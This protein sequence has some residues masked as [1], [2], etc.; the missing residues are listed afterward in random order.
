MRPFGKLIGDQKLLDGAPT[1]VEFAGNR[2]HT[3]ALRVEVADFFKTGNPPGPALVLV[4]FSARTAPRIRCHFTG[5]AGCC[6]D[7]RHR[8]RRWLHWRR[9][10]W[11]CRHR[12][13][14]GRPQTGLV[15]IKQALQG[16]PEI[17]EQMKPIRHLDRLG[18]TTRGSVRKRFGA[19]PTNHFHAGV[20]LQPLNQR[21]RQTIR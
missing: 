7:Y 14:G 9:I 10:A 8:R 5:G 2:P 20:I 1:D 6:R 18:R 13:G 4:L 16:F 12:I 21:V 15:P 17:E 11:G 3:Q 19:I